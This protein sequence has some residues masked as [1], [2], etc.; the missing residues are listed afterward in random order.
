VKR[1]RLRLLVLVDLV[2]IVA[3]VAVLLVWTPQPSSAQAT[4]TIHKVDDATFSPQTR[5]DP[6]F[7]LLI[8]T[9]NRA[10]LDGTRGDAL[11]LVGVNPAAGSATILNI[12][13]DTY[14]PI[15]G[16]GEGKINDAYKRGGFGKQVETVAAFTGITPSFVVE[17][18]FDG[19]MSMIDEMGGL[20]VN[21]PY[22]MFDKNSGADFQPGPVHMSGG[23]A[24]SYARNRH[25][26][27]GD[28][29]RTTNQAWL[30]ISG[31]QRARDV[32]TSP[33]ETIRLM[34][35]M[36]RY[37][38]YDGVSLRELYN[39]IGLGTSIDPANV[40]NVTAPSSIGK[41]GPA[42]VVFSAPGSQE[43]FADLRDD[44]ILESH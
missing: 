30:L 41:V 32:N 19:F 6:F 10:G 13:R 26:P 43:L 27:D 31:L 20:D 28:I 21:V 4:F 8:G 3:A 40:R 39:L 34:G 33:L 5:T 15:P 7:V 14:V 2:L 35:M 12:P 18:N 9:D 25:I 1:L 36:A 16:M 44:A 37:T 11:H 23:T 42:D 22:R 24:L 17:I 29:A 38:H